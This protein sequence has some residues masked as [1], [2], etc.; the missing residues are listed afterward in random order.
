MEIMLILNREEIQ[1]K[2]PYAVICE[3]HESAAW[4]TG[5]RRRL[6]KQTFTEAEQT[7]AERL[8]KMAHK[9]HLVTGVP[10]KVKMLPSTLYL[11]KKL[12]EFCAAI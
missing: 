4:S 1:R 12:G 8:F 2:I 9:W 6:W 10:D 11:W 5:R 7:A 3:T